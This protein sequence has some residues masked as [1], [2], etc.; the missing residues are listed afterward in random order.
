MVLTY[1]I[2]FFVCRQVLHNF[3]TPVGA[4]GKLPNIHDI[5]TKR[6]VA[7]TLGLFLPQ[8]AI[9]MATSNLGK[10]MSITGNVAG[11]MLGYILPGLVGIAAKPA[12]APHYQ[13]LKPGA[14]GF[15]YE[16][17]DDIGQK[18]LV[19]FGIVSAIMGIVS[20]VVN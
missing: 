18:A 9:V 7:Y 3:L 11:S 4:D 10:V 16:K 2:T 13:K 14:W 20:A 17:F 8:M 12:M 5:S 6:H 19:V 1:P 15:S